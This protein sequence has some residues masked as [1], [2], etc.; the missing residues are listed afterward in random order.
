MHPILDSIPH[1]VWVAT[2]DGSTTYVNDFCVEYTGRPRAV[3]YQWGWTSLVHPADAELAER[4]WRAAVGNGAEFQTEYRIHRHDGTFRWHAFRARPLRAAD[5]TI[6]TWVGSA[7]D[8]HDEKR[9]A[10][11]LQKTEREAIEMLTL[12][13]SVDAAA[14]VGFKLVD[15]EFR[16]VRINERLARANGMP[17][18]AH[19]G[20]KVSEVAPQL[21][22]QLE[23]V[24]QQALMG[25]SCGSL[26]LT[27]TSAEE[28][29]RQLHWLASFF[30]VRVGDEIVG[31]GNVVVDVTDRHEADEFRAVVMDNMAEGLYA[32]DAAGSLTYMNLAAS[33]M[34]GW[35]EEDLQ[36]VKVHDVVHFQRGDGEP[37]PED[38]CDL[39]A[40]RT[41]GR[42]IRNADD[43]FTR[44]DG[45]IL[46]VAYSAAPLRTGSVISGVVVVFRDIADEI[47][48]RDAFRRE[49]DALTWIGRIREAIE[50]DRLVLFTQPIRPL[51]DAHRPSE[52]LLVRMI[53]RDGSVVLPGSFLPVA[54]KYG[55][56]VEID[57]WAIAQAIRRAARGD[58]VVEVNVSA[59]SL[60]TAD[61]LSFITRELHESGADPANLV[62]EITETALMRD[63]ELGEAFAHGLAELGCGLAL[64]DFGTGFGSLTYLKRL[65]LTHVKIDIEFVR[66]LVNNE[67]NRRV[68]EVI[69]GLA[70]AFGLHTIAE[71]VEDQET[72][73]QLRAEGVEYAQGFHIGRPAPIEP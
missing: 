13:D 66:D 62:F 68:V 14:P 42:T 36:G 29:D 70:R 56:I 23:P 45:T 47:R 32:V 44:K 17:P 53:G 27:T 48:E 49:I 73:E 38:A 16:I 30:P 58:L 57:R 40:V 24:Y 21:W 59:A 10:A 19:I 61:L 51:S 31:V 8:I 39:L 15:H 60:G 43:A 64:D 18:G 35:S 46:R 12:L 25:E 50:E 20:R 71:G 72:L 67:A 63:I 2:P 54:E 65:P 4:C 52:E 1:I 41:R 69:V 9:F 22:S 55:L 11:S 33:R 28:P 7:T 34:L 5:G 3:N 37:I 26:D 6:H